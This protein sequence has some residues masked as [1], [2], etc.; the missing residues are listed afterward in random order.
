MPIG[1]KAVGLAA[2]IAIATAIHTLVVA[3]TFSQTLPP[4]NSTPSTFNPSNDQTSVSALDVARPILI[5]GIAA[6]GLTALGLATALL[7]GKNQEQLEAQLKSAKEIA[8][9]VKKSPLSLNFSTARGYTPTDENEDALKS[10][11]TELIQNYHTQALSQAATQF[12]FSLTAASIGFIVILYTAFG[13][14][15]GRQV[16]ITLLNTLPGVAI[17]A[18]AA[19]FFKQAE[20]T[21]KRATELYDRLRVDDK[22]TQALALIESIQNQELK[23]L[24]KAQ[25]ALLIVGLEPHSVNLNLPTLPTSVSDDNNKS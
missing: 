23:D 1:K 13:S 7:S 8:N 20:D 25:W 3:P 15:R 19:L 16:Y 14:L 10:V 21:R 9:V 24:V 4:D 5:A 12:W 11:A 17:E 6:I 18:V 2:I 22:Q